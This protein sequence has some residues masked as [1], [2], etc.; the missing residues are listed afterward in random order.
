[1]PAIVSRNNPMTENDKFI[2]D[3]VTQIVCVM[4]QCNL[5]NEEGVSALIKRLGDDI[6]A[7]TKRDDSAVQAG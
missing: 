5:V 6:A 4:I 1:M 3:K 7:V 2:A